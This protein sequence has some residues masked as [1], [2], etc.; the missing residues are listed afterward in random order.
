MN[1]GIRL[2]VLLVLA[3]L[4]K[5][6]QGQEG[7][8]SLAT[9]PWMRH[10]I[11]DTSLGSDGTK[12]ADVNADGKLDLVVGWEEGGVARVYLQ[13][14]DP[15]KTWPYVEVPAPDVEDAFAADLDG[16]G[17]WDLITCSEG[18]H[19][20][21]TIHW[22]PADPEKYLDSE[23]WR[24]EAI[25]ATLGKTRWMFGR[26]ADL[27][28]LN[29]PDLLVGSKDPNG[30]IGWLEAPADPRNMEGWVYHE[31]SPAGWIMSI[32][33]VDMNGNGRPDLL[34]TDRKGSL[35][36]LRWFENPG[37]SGVRGGWRPHVLGMR[38]G[39]PMFLGRE[40]GT[41]APPQ[42]IVVADLLEGW[43]LFRRQGERWLSEWRAYPEGV[44]TRGKSALLTDL[45]GDGK[46]DLIFSF[47]GALGKSGLAA[48]MDF[49][50]NSPKLVDISGPEGVKYD[51]VTAIDLDEDGDPDLITSEETAADGSKKG[52]GVIWY[53]NPAK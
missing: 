48:L 18:A 14:A 35:R 3:F 33:W 7:R 32:E 1:T 39:E 37:F 22:A 26:A 51:F 41:D 25:P 27:D 29:G 11:D 15:K 31:I 50:A 47:E 40:P 43:A 24:S 19:Q 53:E 42:A 46:T 38:A 44:G 17:Q 21:V 10:T 16:D 8:S 49:R 23:A 12:A 9:G 36:G 28:G 52:L 34:I 20:R 2:G 30:T 13:P 6:G 5:A 45:D 4:P